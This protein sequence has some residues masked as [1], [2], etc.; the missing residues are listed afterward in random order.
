VNKRER[1][2]VLKNDESRLVSNRSI[3]KTNEQIRISVSQEHFTDVYRQM[4]IEIETD[5]ISDSSLSISA[6]LNGTYWIFN[7]CVVRKII[8]RKKRKVLFCCFVSNFQVH[9]TQFTNWPQ[10]VRKK[11]SIESIY[12]TSPISDIFLTQKNSK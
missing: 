2:V 10:Y 3:I 4:L 6:I 8:I 7:D 5:T 11:N 12:G 9:N 1:A